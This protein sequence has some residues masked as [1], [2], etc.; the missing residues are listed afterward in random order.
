M[1]VHYTA[2]VANLLFV[3]HKTKPQTKWMDY[4]FLFLSASYKRVFVVTF[5]EKNKK[6]KSFYPKEKSESAAVS[7][8]AVVVGAFNDESTNIRGEGGGLCRKTQAG[9]VGRPIFHCL[10]T[11][12]SSFTFRWNMVDPLCTPAPTMIPVMSTCS[13]R[14][15][16]QAPI[17]R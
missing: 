17:E 9:N 2:K 5:E 13:S 14:S 3:W 4:N 11:C 16:W 7:Y 8:L 10:Q 1:R 15:M 12:W 6:K